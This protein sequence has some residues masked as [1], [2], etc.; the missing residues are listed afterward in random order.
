MTPRDQAAV[1]LPALPSEASARA[2]MLA[3]LAAAIVRELGPVSAA[4]LASW[5]DEAVEDHGAD[6]GR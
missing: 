3:R 4:A 6:G 2:A 1:R 5:I